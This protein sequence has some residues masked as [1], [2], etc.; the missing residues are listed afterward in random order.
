MLTRG[1][2]ERVGALEGVGSSIFISQRSFA[3][4]PTIETRQS[5]ERSLRACS[6]TAA[7]SARTPGLPVLCISTTTAMIESLLLRFGL[8]PHH[9]DPTI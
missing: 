5:P 1:A 9:R 8:N 6:I 4:E 2:F 3:W 7:T